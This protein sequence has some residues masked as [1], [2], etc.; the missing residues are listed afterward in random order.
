MGSLID[1][2][3]QIL[4]C[5]HE[6]RIAIVRQDYAS[7]EQILEK[8]QNLIQTS[9]PLI[10]NILSLVGSLSNGVTEKYSFT[11]SLEWLSN[12]LSADNLDLLLFAGQLSVITLEIKQHTRSLLAA[13][14]N[15]SAHSTHAQNYLVKIS[16]KPVK[17]ALMT[18]E[19]D[20]LDD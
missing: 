3:R 7:L 6:E 5:I 18:V 14:E 17:A 15:Q 1:M 8:R 16:D 2:F 9:D 19:A 13:L 4:S 10:A 20:D 12:H 11:E